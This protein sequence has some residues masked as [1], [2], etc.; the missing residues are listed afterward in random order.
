MKF[1]KTSIL[2]QLMTFQIMIIHEL[3]CHNEWNNRKVNQRALNILLYMIIS[4]SFSKNFVNFCLLTGMPA[5]GKTTNLYMYDIIHKYC[6]YTIMKAFCDTKD[7][8]QLLIN[9][10]HKLCSI[11]KT[12]AIFV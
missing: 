1:F 2:P 5:M 7:R 10:A 9:Y 12:N 11:C 8:T 3:L 4:Y 6:I